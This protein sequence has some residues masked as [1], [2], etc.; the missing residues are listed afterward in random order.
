MSAELLG[1][2]SGRGIPSALIKRPRQARSAMTRPSLTM[3]QQTFRS[4]Q[5]TGKAI[6]I[7]KIMFS[8]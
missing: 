6:L 8:S 3:T 4:P 7:R 1:I 5:K 2:P